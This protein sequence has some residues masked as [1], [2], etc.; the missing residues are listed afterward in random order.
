M[1]AAHPT[2]QLPAIARVTDLD[3]GLQVL[4]RVNDRGP[5]ER[6]RR[7]RADAA[8]R[9]NCWARPGSERRGCACR[10]SS[11]ESR[12]LAAEVNAKATP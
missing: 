12:Q 10:C 9:C 4:V 7:D 8:R 2:L 3:T 5:A 11:D 1:A 6:G